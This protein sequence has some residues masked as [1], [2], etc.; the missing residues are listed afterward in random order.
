LQDLR[1]DPK[2]DDRAREVCALRPLAG[3]EAR[4]A[5]AGR[6]LLDCPD[7]SS[8]ESAV[9]GPFLVS[10]LQQQA[11]TAPALRL[12]LAEEVYPLFYDLAI[13]A[14]RLWQVVAEALRPLVA[15]RTLRATAANSPDVIAMP[16][17][18]R[19]AMRL[20]EA[21]FTGPEEDD[22]DDEPAP[23]PAPATAPAQTP[24]PAPAAAAPA[25]APA[26][27]A[28]PAVPK[29]AVY[30]P[31]HMRADPSFGGLASSGASGR[32]QAGASTSDAEAKAL[33]DAASGK[34]K[35]AKKPEDARAAVAASDAEAAAV[36][37]SMGGKK[38]KKKK[39]AKE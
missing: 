35:K 5:A 13:D 34:K 31:R 14:P 28:A 21:S 20:D 7:W 23:A 37:A 29:V 33:L 38:K 32:R 17:K 8:D 9:V 11:F 36:L 25:P 12:Y 3:P 2:P 22:D 24:A 15:A 1:A 39:A 19:A 26:P 27:A 4:V 30:M 10:L 6:A 18:L 16:T